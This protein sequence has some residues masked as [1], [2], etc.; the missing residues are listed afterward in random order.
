M[1]RNAQFSCNVPTTRID[2]PLSEQMFCGS[3]NKRVSRDSCQFENRKM[4]GT[5]KQDQMGDCSELAMNAP[6][7][8]LEANLYRQEH[9]TE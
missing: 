4:F 3:G 2:Q 8:A 7:I 5:Q 1:S 9:R 6:L